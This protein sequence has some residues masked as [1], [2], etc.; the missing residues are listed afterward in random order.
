MSLLQ[1]RV[2]QLEVEQFFRLSI[3][4]M[5][6]TKDSV[7]CVQCLVN[8]NSPLVLTDL[9]PCA[10]ATGESHPIDFED[11]LGIESLWSHKNLWVNMQDCSN[12]L[13]VVYMQCGTYCISW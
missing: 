11:Y 2:S 5:S 8:I 3:F 10:V 1:T 6:I 7:A 13:K 12:G 4:G 9:Y